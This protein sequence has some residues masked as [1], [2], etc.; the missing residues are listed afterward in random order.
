M[1]RGPPIAADDGPLGNNYLASELP[2]IR[3]LIGAVN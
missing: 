3:E 2:T 1:R